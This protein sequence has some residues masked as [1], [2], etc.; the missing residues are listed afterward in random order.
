MSVNW[1]VAAATT[2]G[3]SGTPEYDAWARMKHRCLNRANKNFDRYGGRGISVCPTWRTSF[4]AFYRDMGPRPHGT[5]LDRIDNEKGYEPG[6]CRWATPTEQANNRRS[7]RIVC[8]R[9]EARS[10][11]EWS[12]RSGV[13]ED[14]IQQRLVKLAWAP[15]PAIFTPARRCER[16]SN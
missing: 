12:R 8:C 2:H 4:A 16:G 9:G 14:V 11:A 6:N 3:M 7:N 15:E 13:S 10:I 5:S 1:R